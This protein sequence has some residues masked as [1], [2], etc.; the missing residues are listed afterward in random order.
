MFALVLSIATG[1]PVGTSDP[2]PKPD[3]LRKS[4]PAA[5]VAGVADLGATPTRA[6]AAVAGAWV[7]SPSVYPQLAPAPN[8]PRPTPHR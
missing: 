6:L 5:A 2:A 8:V 7:L 1:A 3:P 4:A